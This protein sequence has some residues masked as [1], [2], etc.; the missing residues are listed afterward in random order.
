MPSVLYQII[1]AFV[2]VGI[3]HW[4]DSDR[5]FFLFASELFLFLSLLFHFRRPIYEMIESR[6][7]L[8]SRSLNRSYLSQSMDLWC[9]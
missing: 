9:F 3:W 7:I 6:I 8:A 1:T 4:D 2:C 5:R